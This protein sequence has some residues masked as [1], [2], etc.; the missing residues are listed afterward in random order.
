LAKGAPPKRPIRK[1]KTVHL[2]INLTLVHLY[3]VFFDM[4]GTRAFWRNPIINAG[5]IQFGGV[6]IDCTVQNLSAR[7][8]TLVVTSLAG[9]PQKFVLI[10]YAYDV[11]LRCRTVWKQ[12]FRIG[13][14]F[15]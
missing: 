5:K 15:D 1:S 6:V 8:A 13:V 3:P 2:P 11:T 9:I 14:A 12:N 4:V 10:I 7:G